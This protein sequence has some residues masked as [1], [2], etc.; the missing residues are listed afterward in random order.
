MPA[1][2]N[3]L[4][5]DEQLADDMVSFYADPL[6]FVMYAYPW[7]DDPSIQ[8]VKLAPQYRERFKCEYGPDVWACEFLD[9]LGKKIAANDFDGQTAVDPIQEAVSSGHGVGKSAM[10]GWLVNFIMSTRPHCQGTVT[11]NTG[12]QLETKTWAQIAKWTKKCITAHWF[13]VST[14][15]GSMKMYHKQYPE[16]WFCTAQ[17]CREENSEAFAGQHAANS[18]SFYIIDEASAVPDTIWEVQEG[19]LTDGEP[20]RFVFGNPTRNSGRFRECWGKYRQ[21][22]GARKIDSRT[23]QITNKAKIQQWVD[24]EGEDSDFVKVRVRGEFPSVGDKQFIGRDIIDGAVERGRHA[25]P[26]NVD[27]TAPLVIGIDFARSGSDKSVL[28][29]RRGRHCYKPHKFRER[30]SMKAAAILVNILDQAERLWGSRPDAIFGDGGG[31]GG[32]IIDRLNAL[33]QGVLE[34]QFGGTAT[35]SRKWANKRIEMW[36]AMRAWLESG[37]ID[38]DPDLI[39]DLGNPEYHHHGRSDAL[40]LESKEDMKAR[41]LSS[42]DDGDAL[43]LTF[44]HPVVRRAESALG[45]ARHKANNEYNPLSDRL[46]RARSRR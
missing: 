2:Q 34:I 21:R 19:G 26:E 5:I 28:R 20:M 24:D 45:S 16:S 30:N 12:P 11:A 13:N 31:I 23:V 22:W 15:R 6:G 44:A 37:C 1:P 27:M 25:A 36:G 8:I 33:G 18:T 40:V 46:R 9:D 3:E 4:T 17:T 7:D 43:A 14:G 32:P 10:S 41:G 38:A 35:D 39:E 42:P 29:A